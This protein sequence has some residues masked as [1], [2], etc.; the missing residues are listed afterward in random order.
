MSRLR[1]YAYT[2]H[3]RQRDT[4]LTLSTHMHM[5]ATE[6]H[7]K[8]PL[9]DLLGLYGVALHALRQLQGLAVWGPRAFKS[10]TFNP[11]WSL[12]RYDD[13]NFYF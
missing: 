10:S 8:M 1:Q 12:G 11:N 6:W 5:K 4:Q 2:R 9:R 13:N 3:T 7:Y